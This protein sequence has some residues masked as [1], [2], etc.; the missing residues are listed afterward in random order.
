MKAEVKKWGNSAVIR[1][2]KAVMEQCQ[3]E[4]ASP[5]NMQ[6]E[7]NKL[8]IEL[9]RDIEYSLDALLQQCSP[10]KMILSKDD[11]EWLSSKPVGKELL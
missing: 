11:K 2:P 9:D 7:G 10:K 4:V 6:V 1:I 5:I 8:I 3:F